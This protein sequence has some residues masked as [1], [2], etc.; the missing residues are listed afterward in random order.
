MIYY[1]VNQTEVIVEVGGGGFGGVVLTAAGRAGID[2]PT[3]PHALL[4]YSAGFIHV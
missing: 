3:H 2:T 4:A 1:S